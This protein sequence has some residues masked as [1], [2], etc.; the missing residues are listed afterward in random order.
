MRKA[1]LVGLVFGLTAASGAWAQQG[2]TT[3]PGEVPGQAGKEGSGATGG[4]PGAAAG[5]GQGDSVLQ[6]GLKM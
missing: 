3:A 2:S 6:S 5:S 1:L 4:V